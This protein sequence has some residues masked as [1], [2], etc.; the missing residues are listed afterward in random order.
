MESNGG[1][2]VPRMVVDGVVSSLEP[3]RSALLPRN[4]SHLSWRE[5]KGEISDLT[6]DLSRGAGLDEMTPSHQE[7]AVFCGRQ[8]GC[9]R[10]TSPLCTRT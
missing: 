8:E 4:S 5:G 1:Q 10:A 7:G 9:S 6:G 3:E 2:R